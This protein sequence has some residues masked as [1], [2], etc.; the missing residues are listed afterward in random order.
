MTLP[1]P[2]T[3]VELRNSVAVRAGVAT[4]GT[5]AS[6]LYDI[7]DEFLASCQWEIYTRYSHARLRQTYETL[8][9]MLQRDF[10]IPS[11]CRIGTLEKVSMLRVRGEV[12]TDPDNYVPPLTLDE[13]DV[14]RLREVDLKYDERTPYNNFDPEVPA[15]PQTWQI[16]NDLIR[17]APSV[18][19]RLFPALRIY[20]AKAPTPLVAEADRC[21]V[22]G[23]GLKRMTALRVQDY[24]GIGGD[25]DTEM[26]KVERYLKDLRGLANP[27]TS[28][29]LASDNPDGP[30]YWTNPGIDAQNQPYTPNWGPW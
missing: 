26:M 29:N 7:V 4:N 19:A 13:V 15:T 24:L 22:D 23:E 18:D 20:Y 25:L 5:L 30:R 10:D 11:D 12:A 27:A 2:P 9:D 1:L 21:V 28:F 17:V 14:D 3:L 8:T 16:L 6:S